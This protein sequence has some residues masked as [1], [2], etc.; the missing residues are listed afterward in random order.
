MKQHGS[1]IED[2]TIHLQVIFPLAGDEEWYFF[3]L[4]LSE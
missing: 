2:I 1:W 3:C 4:P